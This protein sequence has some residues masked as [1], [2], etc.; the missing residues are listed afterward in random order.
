MGKPRLE[1]TP[2]ERR[3]ERFK[4]WLSP[5]GVTFKSK[6]AEEQYKQRVTR[7][8]KEIKP[9]KPDRVPVMLPAGSFPAYYEGSNLKECVYEY[10][11]LKRYWLKFLQDFRNDMY[12]FSGPGLIT[13]VKVL[14]ITGHKLYNWPGH[15][16]PDN[17]SFNQYI[18]KEYM[19]HDQYDDLIRDWTDYWLR[20]FMTLEA[21]AF[22][23]RE[24]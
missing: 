11:V 13:L 19:K 6:R 7:F 1:M 21:D 16:L 20:K 5:K 24:L 17:V 2:T 8:I 18:E 10:K 3:E 12:T 4:R 15:R 23:G 22:R 14:E 9:E